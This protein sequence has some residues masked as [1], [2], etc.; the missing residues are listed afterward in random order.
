MTGRPKNVWFKMEIDSGNAAVVEDPIGAVLHAF[1]QV[2]SRL[3][4]LTSD[5]RMKLLDRNG[6]EIGR[7]WLTVTKENTD[8]D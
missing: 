5:E 6:N 8:E 3:P 4:I 1:G 2:R 7:A